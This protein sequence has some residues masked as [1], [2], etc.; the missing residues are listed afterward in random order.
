MRHLRI[1]RAIRLIVRHGSIRKAAEYLPISPSA[2]NRSIQS[3]EDELGIPL[4]DRLPSGMQLST[5]GEL[6]FPAFDAHLGSFDRL[7]ESLQAMRGGQTGTVSIGISDDLAAGAVPL[8]LADIQAQAPMLTVNLQIANDISP[9]AARHADLSVLTNAVT[10]ER[11]AVVASFRSPLVAIGPAKSPTGAVISRFSDLADCR[12][13]LPPEG[14]GTRIRIEHL[15][16]KNR[17]TPR[18]TTVYPG[19]WSAALTG[20]IPEVQILPLVGLPDLP[21][22]RARCD[23][24]LGDVQ[25]TILRRTESQLSRSLENL[26]ARIQTRMDSLLDAV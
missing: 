23:I 25:I 16:R 13:I 11:F 14:T 1:Y 24:P 12:V 3:F 4:F 19:L 20:P 22:H 15:L 21:S 8:A 26:V 2:L 5:A 7:T 10:D 6:F 17:L 18:A 9:L